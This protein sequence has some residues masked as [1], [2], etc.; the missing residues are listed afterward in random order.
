MSEGA[1][2]LVGELAGYRRKNVVHVS[3]WQ[4]LDR[5]SVDN[6]DIRLTHGNGRCGGG[7]RSRLMCDD[8]RAGDVNWNW[9]WN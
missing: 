8:R 4:L 9:N 7:D 6:A 2:V 5:L 3:N 1:L